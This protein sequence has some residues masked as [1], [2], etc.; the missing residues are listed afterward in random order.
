MRIQVRIKGK[1][2]KHWSSW[3]EDLDISHD[4]ERE[5][6]LLSGE[7]PDQ[8]ALYGV[9]AR[10]RDL[11]L[12]LLSVDADLNEAVDFGAGDISVGDAGDGG[13]LDT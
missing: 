10:L 12:A 13:A 3:F 6:T 11:G 5:E 1:I 7:I 4:R 9:L 2:D 8:A